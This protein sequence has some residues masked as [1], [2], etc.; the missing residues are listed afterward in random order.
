[1]DIIFGSVW[2]VVVHHVTDVVN[3]KTAGSDV[4]C[5]ENGKTSSSKP[6]QS[7]TSL[8]KSTVPVQNCNPMSKLLE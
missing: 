8:G 7:G 4:R 2:K 1:V 6:F 5:Y 3:I